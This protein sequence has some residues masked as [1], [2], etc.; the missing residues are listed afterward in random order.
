MTIELAANHR[1][2]R[3]TRHVPPLAGC[4][5][6]AVCCLTA[7]H[8]VLAAEKNLPVSHARSDPTKGEG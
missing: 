2:P 8:L 6:L 3:N 1:T 5:V 4:L 7:G